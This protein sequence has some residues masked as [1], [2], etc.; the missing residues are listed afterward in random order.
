VAGE[1]SALKLL[2]DL[3]NQDKHRG[4]IT[5]QANTSV[6]ALDVYTGGATGMRNGI[7]DGVRVELLHP[8]RT[9]VDGQAFA[10]FE[11]SVPVE[12]GLSRQPVGLEY[13]VHCGDVTYQ[14]GDVQMALLSLQGLM[15]FV[16]KGY[17]PQPREETS[18]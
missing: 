7:T 18:T 4:M 12:L 10:R 2:V 14:L 11:T 17:F 13:L 6:F 1:G 5:A 16:E 3:S 8:V 9:L 15:V